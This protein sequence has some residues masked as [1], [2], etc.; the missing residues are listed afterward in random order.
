MPSP[1]QKGPDPLYIK[2]IDLENPKIPERDSILVSVSSY[3]LIVQRKQTLRRKMT[4]RGH[5]AN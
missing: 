3:P 5:T 4:S 1:H 2:G